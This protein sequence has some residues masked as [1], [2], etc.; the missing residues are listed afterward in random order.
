MMER[1][2]GGGA[3]KRTR[4]G[5]SSGREKLEDEQG[6]AMQEGAIRKGDPA[7]VRQIK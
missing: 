5:R 7:S 6:S 4:T 3:P 1:L 2:R